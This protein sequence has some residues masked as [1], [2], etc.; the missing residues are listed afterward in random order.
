[1]VAGLQ[2][3][4]MS[5]LA[6]KFEK[7]DGELIPLRGLRCPDGYTEE[8]AGRLYERVANELKKLTSG[9]REGLLNDTTL[10]LLYVDRCERG[11]GVLLDRFGVEALLA[12]LSVPESVRMRTPNEIGHVVNMLI[13]TIRQ[14]LRRLRPLQSV[15]LEEVTN[16]DN[17]TCLLLPPKTFGS[18]FQT[19]REQVYAAVRDGDDPDDFRTRLKRVSN[20]FPTARRNHFIGDRGIIFR[21]PAKARHGLAPIWEDGTHEPSCVI[22]GRIRFGMSF[23]PRF[24]YDCEMGNRRVKT[25]PGCHER[26]TVRRDRRHVNVAPNDNV[27]Q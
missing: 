18:R 4:V 8:Y 16:R 1:M 19:V 5:R 11:D 21:S 26:Q 6:T 17:R 2:T 7:R 9:N 3:E 23:D 15:I 27:R 20:S 25:L 12:P 10:T 13:K 24:H 22:R 14:V